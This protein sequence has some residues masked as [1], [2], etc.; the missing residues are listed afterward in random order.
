MSL[1]FQLASKNGYVN[2]VKYLVSLGADIRKDN[3]RAIQLAAEGNHLETVEY[4]VSVADIR[5]ND[6]YVL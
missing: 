1:I 6:N 5:A 3:D 2:I 4:L